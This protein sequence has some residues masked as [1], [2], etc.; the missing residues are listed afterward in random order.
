[1]E[2]RNLGCTEI[3]V[4]ELCFGALPM[5]PLQ[6]NL[7]VEE[8]GKLIREALES[9]INFIDT[10]QMY[11]TYNHIAHGLKGFSGDVVVA[12]KSAAHDYQGMENAVQEALKVLNRDVIDIFH[13]H[14]A[15]VT[16]NVFKEREGALK[17]LLDYKDKGY[18]RAIGISTHNIKV[19]EKAAE[20]QEIDIVYPIINKTGRGILEGTVED[21]LAAIEKCDIAGKG[22]YAMKVLAGG[23]LI[24]ELLEAIKFGRN[25]KGMDSISIG[26]IRKEELEL[27]L[28]IFNNESITEDMLPKVISTKKL[29]ILERFC[30]K[31]GKCIK[32]C[33]NGA[34]ELGEKSV[35][36]N[37]DICLL[38]GYCYPVCPEFA[39]RMV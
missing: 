23:N 18:I 26:M 29:F 20:I 10:A 19:V 28:K 33:P 38:C 35:K 12:T 2:L 4:S 34:M 27:N 6:A 14:A 21:M 15:R 1:M 3:T 17:C 24:G 11:Q 7:T 31:C 39:I 36:V 25:I 32:A 16:P 5:G 37:H 22:L 9:G 13:L 8:G 30:K